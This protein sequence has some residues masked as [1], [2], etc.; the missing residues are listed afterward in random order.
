[1]SGLTQDQQK[2]L[3]ENRRIAQER[4][5]RKRSAPLSLAGS[6]G[7][8]QSKRPIPKPTSHD[9]YN[10][11]SSSINSSNSSKHTSKTG[12]T[13]FV[14]QKKQVM[15]VLTLVSPA[16]FKVS[17]PYDGKLIELFKQVPSKKYGNCL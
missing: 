17:V 16:R 13:S 11:W 3:E 7:E 10:R 5:A 15:A 4:L 6:S 8:P 1:M 2:R 9:N 14:T 12:Q